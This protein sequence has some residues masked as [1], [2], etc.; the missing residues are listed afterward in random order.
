MKKK[1]LKDNINLKS[2]K[3]NLNHYYNYDNSYYI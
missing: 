3:L 2:K 1:F